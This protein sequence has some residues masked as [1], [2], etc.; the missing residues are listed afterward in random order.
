MTRQVSLAPGPLARALHLSARYGVLYVNN[1][2]VACSTIKL[3]LQRAERG[4]PSFTPKPSVHSH[5]ASPLLTFADFD[6]PDQALSTALAKTPFVFSFVRNPF[7]RLISA[8]L[9]KIVT[10]QKQGRFREEAGFDART[11]PTLDDFVAAVCSQDPL[12]QNPHWRVQGYNLSW[13]RIAY[14]FI[15]RLENFDMDWAAFTERMGLPPDI[16]RA[17]RRTSHQTVDLPTLSATSAEAI[18]RCFAF[19][20]VTFGYP[21]DLP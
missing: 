5:S 17:G 4:D 14:D 18:R 11:C 13:D 6:P 19:D 12:A 10:G 20:F 3:S 7:S 2:K 1:P 21:L 9:N 8:Y 16:H 15:G